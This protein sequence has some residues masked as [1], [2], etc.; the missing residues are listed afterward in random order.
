MLGVVESGRGTRLALKALQRP[1]V[2]G[3]RL[4]QDLDS[5]GAAEPRV[6]GAVH[7]AHTARTQRREDFIGPQFV[8]GRKCHTQVSVQFTQTKSGLG[9]GSRARKLA[10]PVDGTRPYLMWQVKG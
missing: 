9:G 6:A 8:P 1:A 2:L 10:G 7:L 4:W 5:D 3:Q